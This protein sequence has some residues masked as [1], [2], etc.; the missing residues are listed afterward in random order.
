MD[1]HLRPRHERHADRH[2]ASERE[3]AARYRNEVLHLCVP[4]PL[5]DDT[6][7]LLRVVFAWRRYD[8]DILRVLQFRLER[9]RSMDDR[10]QLPCY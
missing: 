6:L 10:L 3:A 7:R 2:R 4:L 1:L 8:C 5:D 9:A